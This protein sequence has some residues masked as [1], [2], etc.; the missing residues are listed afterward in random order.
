[1]SKAIRWHRPVF[2]RAVHGSVD[3]ATLKQRVKNDAASKWLRAHDLEQ[4]QQHQRYGRDK[5]AKQ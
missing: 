1:M 4:H 5:E 3:R 2:R